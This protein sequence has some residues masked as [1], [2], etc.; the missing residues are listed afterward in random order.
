MVTTTLAELYAALEAL[1]Y[2]ALV[3]RAEIRE[4]EKGEGQG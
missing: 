2:A 4:R 1:E 3:V